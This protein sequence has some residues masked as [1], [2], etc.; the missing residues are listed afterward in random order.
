MAVIAPTEFRKRMNRRKWLGWAFYAL[1]L[2]AISIA[3]G[4]LA[5]AAGL[6]RV[7]RLVPG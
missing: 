1:C 7:K 4:M 6:Y 5:V 2:L 3:L